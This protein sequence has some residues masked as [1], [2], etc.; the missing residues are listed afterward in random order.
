MNSVRELMSSMNVSQF[1]VN[2]IWT[3]KCWSSL[4]KR[5]K[6]A[7]FTQHTKHKTRHL[8]SIHPFLLSWIR[9]FIAQIQKTVLF[10]TVCT[11]GESTDFYWI[12][13][14]IWLFCHLSGSR[15]CFLKIKDDV[16]FFLSGFF[17]S[18]KP[19]IFSWEAWDRL[20]ESQGLA[21]GTPGILF[22]NNLYNWDG[23]L[24]QHHRRD[25]TKAS[26]V[27][28]GIDDLNFVDFASDWHVWEER[29]LISCIG[30]TKVECI[31][32]NCRK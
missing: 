31:G 29:D 22:L 25:E 32:T 5:A 27:I 6:G 11:E 16:F 2:I 26:R 4:V 19:G 20:L 1:S 28:S 14:E 9:P 13:F 24:L 30:L 15:S 18:G 12:F 17:F 10:W 7:S 23:I 21:P 3:I 8:R